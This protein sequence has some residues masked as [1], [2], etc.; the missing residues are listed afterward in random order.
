MLASLVGATLPLILKRL[1]MDP[2]LGPVA[3][4]GAP[5]VAVNEVHGYKMVA[6]S[7][8]PDVTPEGEHEIYVQAWSD[9][10]VSAVRTDT[11]EA[12]IVRTAYWFAWSTY[13]PN[14]AVID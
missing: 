12:L 10:G 1:G 2:A 13:F 9:G 4:A 7:G 6:W 5:A 11:D 8:A 14:T 3:G